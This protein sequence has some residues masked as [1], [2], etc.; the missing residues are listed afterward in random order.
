M[1][2]REPVVGELLVPIQEDLVFIP[3]Y[4]TVVDKAV[5]LRFLRV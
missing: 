5:E 4:A 1:A 2:P 3:N